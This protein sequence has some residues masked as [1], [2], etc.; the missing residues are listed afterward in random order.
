MTAPAPSESA[1]APSAASPVVQAVGLEKTF[2]LGTNAVPAL[3]GVDLSVASGEWVAIMGP[4]GCGKTTLLGLL[5][6]LDRPTAGTVLID[7]VDA[8]QLS[9]NQQA[10]LRR[11]RLGFVFQF[12]S[13]VPMLTALENVA[14]P[15]QLAGRSTREAQERAQALLEQVGIGQRAGHLPSELSGGQQQRVAIARALAND[16]ALVL[17]DEPTGDLDQASTRQTLDLLSEL[18]GERGATLVMVTH[19]VKVA[20]AASRVVHMLDGKILHEEARGEDGSF[21]SAPGA[22]EGE[23]P[24]VNR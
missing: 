17:L 10:D 13:L 5:G 12:Y 1:A 6:L 14:V 3:R 20:R 8:A 11:D 4:S 7:G 24:T 23:L 9:E 16:P 22:G 19:D 21:A 2:L 15:M 18:N